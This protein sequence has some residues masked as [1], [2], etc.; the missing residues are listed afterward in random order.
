MRLAT[1][2]KPIWSCRCLEKL[3]FVCVKRSP[4][5]VFAFQELHYQPI[6]AV[7]DLSDAIFRVFDR[8]RQN[9]TQQ[10]LTNG[11]QFVIDHFIL[12]GPDFSG[13]YRFII[14][15]AFFDMTTFE[16]KRHVVVVFGFH[17]K[18]ISVLALCQMLLPRQM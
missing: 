6:K 1:F 3:R 15:A 5:F 13:D 2:P 18:G 4:D 9:V 14:C 17:N 7:Y 12:N 16:F 10:F 8:C 11:E